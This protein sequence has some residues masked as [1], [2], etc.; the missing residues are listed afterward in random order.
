M[1]LQRPTPYRL[2]ELMS[3]EK[4]KMYIGQE[5][6]LYLVPRELI[7][8][9][10]SILKAHFDKK[11]C[12]KKE[13]TFR[14]AKYEQNSAKHLYDCFPEQFDMLLECMMQGGIS[15][16]WTNSREAIEKCIA[17]VQYSGKLDMADMVCEAVVEVLRNAIKSPNS[18]HHPGNF[19][20][21][22]REVYQPGFTAEDVQ[23]VFKVTKHG[24][25]LRALV[26][27]DVLS[28]QGLKG[29]ALRD[30]EVNVPGFA[31]EVLKQFRNSASFWVWT[32]PITG[33]QRNFDGYA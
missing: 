29:A 16:R 13:R 5:E 26:A 23:T 27:Q 21:P 14:R 20:V 8:Y 32:D 4:V 10:S 28:R 24:N 15:K 7:C 6:K 19:T 33:L 22:R 31:A 3:S 11:V 1:A 18:Q 12:I 17:L 2:L 30:A 9:H 25:A